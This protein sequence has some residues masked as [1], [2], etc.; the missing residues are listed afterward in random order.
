MEDYYEDY[1][2]RRVEQ[3]HLAEMPR[4]SLVA[5]TIRKAVRT[6]GRV[7]ELGVGEGHNLANLTGDYNLSCCDISREALKL[8]VLPEVRKV[9]CDLNSSFPFSGEKFDAIICTEVLEHLLRPELLMGRI[10]EALKPEGVAVI[11]IPNTAHLEYRWTL[12]R[13]RFPDFDESHIH[14]WTIRDFFE[15]LARVGFKVRSWQPTY[16]DFWV[17]RHLVRGPI[18]GF[19][20]RVDLAKELFGREIVF[21][22]ARTRTGNP[23]VET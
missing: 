4:H 7:L 10:R 18:S 8:V 17:F 6:G 2:I 22:I 9:Q 3:G 12:L 1:W 21:V 15:F 16:L 19:L 14:F 20:A 13:G 5:A 23:Q 11:S